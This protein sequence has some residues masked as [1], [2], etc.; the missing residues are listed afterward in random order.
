MKRSLLAAVL[1]PPLL[2]ACAAGHTI[3]HYVLHDTFAEA[4]GRHVNARQY[5]ADVKACG[6]GPGAEWCRIAADDGNLDRVAPLELKPLPKGVTYAYD[7]SQCSG[8]FEHGLCHGVS[9]PRPAAAAPV[10]HGETIDGVCS[11]PT[12]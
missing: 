5:E 10:C 12:F 3:D 11:G 7:A 4:H 9:Q 8:T 2:Q 6:A 1:I